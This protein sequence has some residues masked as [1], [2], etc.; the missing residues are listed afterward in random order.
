M[1][2]DLSGV[3]KAAVLLITLGP[4]VAS[5]V[6]QHLKEEEIEEL[7][8][9]IAN[10]RSV[11]PQDK[12]DVLN[13]FYQVCLAQ[14]YIAEGGIGYAKELLEKALGDDKAQSVIAKL[15]AS[16]QV[17]PFEFVRKTEP[18][19]LL[20]FIQDEH[21]Q[22][23]AMILSYLPAGQAALVLGALPPEKQADVARRI[24]QMDR[25]SPDVIKEVEKVLERKLASLV[26]QDYTIVGGIDS[27]VSILNSVDRATE[28][29][30]ME[31]LEIEEP[32]LADEIRKKMFVFEDI[33][34]L[35]DRAIQRVLRDVDNADLEL[36]LKSSTEEVQ[37]VIFKN[38]S[39][40]LAAM[41]KEDMDFM[42]PVRMKDVEEA[43]Q[44]IVAVIR[45]LEDSA[46]IVISRG[47]GD[48]LVV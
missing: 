39:K 28:K 29:H 43:Q 27:V 24:A 45:R 17:R 2:D 33:L 35:D 4:E 36:A 5:T 44:K 31:S 46:E 1:I 25:T 10:T 38:L 20:N 9:E 6:F 26:N 21:P 14:Q 19:Q 16:L 13:E 7:T 47:G 37:N 12:E 34:L 22:T 23:I 18:S 15:T 3:Q 8:L 40:R 41:I 32:E 11:S 30:I 42:G 48:D